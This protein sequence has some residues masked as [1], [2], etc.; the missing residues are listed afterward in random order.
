M[1]LNTFDWIV[2][3]TYLAALIGL[4]CALARGQKTS[5]DYYLAGNKTAPLPIA[6]STMATQCSTNS[7]LGAPAFVAFATGGGMIWLQYELAV[8]FAMIFLMA[9]LF[10]I[11]RRLNLISLYSFLEKRFG[12]GTRVTLSILFQILRAFS[13]GVTV[14]GISLVLKVCLGIPFGVAV[15]LL[16]GITVIYDTLGGMKAVI[17][18]DVIQ[19]VVLFGSILTA[20]GV[21]VSILGGFEEVFSRIQPERL[22]AVD[23]AHHGFG[24]G[25][26]FAFWPML[27]GGLFLY[28]SY[29]GCDQTQAQRELSTRGVNDT[30]RALFLDG[31]LRFPLVVSYCFLGLCLAGY[32]AANP[33]FV[34]SL[35]LNESGAINYNYAV[36]VFVVQHFPHGVIGLVIVGLFAAAMSS[37][38]STLNALSALSMEDIVKR[39]S[40]T[41]FSPRQELLISKMLTVFWGTV[42]IF[43]AFFVGDVSQTVIESVN[44]IGSLINGPLLAVFIM[45]VLS[46]RINSQGAVSGFMT[47]FVVNLLLW[48]F[49]PEVS[50]L[51]WNVI[52]FF[53]AYFTGYLMSKVTPAPMPNGAKNTFFRESRMTA[54]TEGISWRPYYIMLALYGTGIFLFLLLVS[55]HFFNFG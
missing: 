39:F 20:I 36:P 21:A 34:D 53:I 8:P 2:I 15:I 25:Q 40:K 13:T 16:G 27:F 44:K 32:A 17:W 12:P 22:Q 45:G 37:L 9:V 30:N 48:K 1:N 19:L 3:C 31:M 28:V 41:E 42:C 10:P 26:T 55:Q 29:Y 52:G 43:F 5:R 33:S 47:G 46:R 14:Y 6:L 24:D 11:F 51:W 49:V 18:S 38:D 50:W 4:S 54:K 7:L 35:P 23:L